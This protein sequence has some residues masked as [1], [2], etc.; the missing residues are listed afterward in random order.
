MMDTH[1]DKTQENK[2][3]SSSNGES[4]HQHGAEYSPPPFVDNRPS[5]IVQRRMQE[6]VNQSSQVKQSKSYQE[7]ANNQIQAQPSAQLQAVPV[8]L[9]AQQMPPIQKQE[10]NTGLPAGLQSGIESLSDYSMDDVKVH[11]NSDKPAQVQAYAYA[12]GTDIHLGPGQEKH[13]P[14]E[15]WH[16]VQQKQGRVKPTMQLKGNVNINDDAG[17]EKE[18]DVMGNKAFQVGSNQAEEV[19]QS[20]SQEGV[21]TP[22]SSLSTVYQR[23]INVDGRTYT[24][25]DEAEF[26]A[27]YPD[28]GQRHRMIRA[29]SDMDRAPQSIIE[30]LQDQRTFNLNQDESDPDRPDEIDYWAE[31]VEL[32]ERHG[33]LTTRVANR[34]PTLIH[35]P[36]EGREQIV[37]EGMI[38]C[39][40]VIVEALDERGFVIAAVGGHFVS[41]DNMTGGTLNSDGEAWLMQLITQLPPSAKL[42]AMLMYTNMN[43]GALQA[44]NAFLSRNNVSEI[45]EWHGGGKQS[46]ILNSDGSTSH[47]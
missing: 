21:N 26:M 30:A 9:S 19:D 42:G 31:A 34:A 16:V 15:A 40:G 23:A 18:A 44:V 24:A 35:R 38:S 36:G 46:Y 27:R 4:I 22:P 37:I 5:A 29:L 33:D 11:Y 17:L 1:I 14:H 47:Q 41:P 20:Q 12:Q 13:L 7:I 2:E 8:R 3:Q 45:D 43:D 28:E 39:V 25:A 32:V 6:I 10:N